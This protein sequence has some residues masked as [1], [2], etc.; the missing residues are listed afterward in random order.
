MTDKW[1]YDLCSVKRQCEAQVYKF[2]NSETLHIV[3]GFEQY[4]APNTTDVTGEIVSIIWIKYRKKKS[5]LAFTNIQNFPFKRDPWVCRHK[6]RWN[7]RGWWME[8]EPQET[9]RRETLPYPSVLAHTNFQSYIQCNNTCTPLFCLRCMVSDGFPPLHLGCDRSR[10]NAHDFHTLR[11]ELFRAGSRPAVETA[12]CHCVFTKNCGGH[13]PVEAGDVNNDSP[14]VLNHLGAETTC[15]PHGCREVQCNGLETEHN[16][17]NVVRTKMGLPK[18]VKQ[19]CGG[20]T[21]LSTKISC[22]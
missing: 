1:R 15:Q 4:V 18:R 17:S 12:L 13:V 5:S 20:S 2:K 9:W 6:K 14:F 19:R 11:P 10:L 3:N 21:A 22:C 16:A 7:T 8:Q